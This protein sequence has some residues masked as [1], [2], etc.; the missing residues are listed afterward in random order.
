MH[1]KS[2]ARLSL[3]LAFAVAA[4][5]AMAQQIPVTDFAKYADLDEVALSP[6]GEYIALAVPSVDGK[7]T[8]L[9]IVKLAD[10]S[11]VKTLRFGQE[12]H[13]MG[14]TWTDD[15]QIT[16]A[17][18]KR[19]PGEEF[20]RNTGQLMAT[21]LTGDKQ[22]TLFAYVLDDGT[23]RGR[24]K[25]LGSAY[26]EKVLDKEPGKVLV[27][28]YC[29]E[30]DCGEDGD[31]VVFKVDTRTGT[32]QEVERIK[33]GDVSSSLVFDTDGIARIAYSEESDGTPKLSYRATATSA[34]AP[35]PKSIAGYHL[36]GGV[37]AEDNN[38]LYARVSD[39]GEATQLY[40]IDVA[41]GTRTK[42]VNREGVNVGTIMTATRKE[43]PFGV[44]YTSPS[45]AVQYF[46]NNSEW[47]KLHNALLQRFKGKMVYFLD[48]TRDDSKVLFWTSGD[49]DMGNYY[50]LDRANGNKITQVGARAPWFEGKALAAMKPIEF[51]TRDGVK[52]Y[53]YYTAPV[54]GG[55]GPKPLVV[56]P[57]GGP[58]AVFDA[59][60]FDRDVQF[61]ASRGY[62]VLQVNYRGSGGRGHK[63]IQQAYK[64]WGGMIQNDITDGVKYAIDQKLAD[65]DR[66][67]MYGGSFGGYSALMQPILNPGMYKCA[68]GYVGVYD[69]PLLNS[70]KE[71]EDESV[72][73]FFLRSLGTDAA[74]LGKLS[75]AKR[76]GEVK[77]PVMLVHGKADG[78]VGMNQFRAMDGALK[79][80]GNPAETF[81]GAGEGH[82]FSNPENI[83]ELYRRME[84]FLD[85][86]IGP[87]A[88]VATSP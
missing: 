14:V 41:A 25:D 31:T 83:A 73:R 75:P 62:G 71:S 2:F 13:V 87:N 22:R 15:D 29:W 23:K 74:S 17:R 44:T 84:A 77:V 88:K 49:R 66:I 52:L 39:E 7:E 19:Y 42:M 5:V 64:E 35:L 72:E 6:T 21:N 38:T 1:R 65:P 12:S 18:A 20:L 53:G 86:H 54:G 81:L 63:F 69:L 56:M 40:K 27:N 36:V 43:V 16:V 70:S 28:F 10:G 76:A 78:N 60:G 57:H 34:W 79:D 26:L 59:W 37:F 58:F 33:D 24:N 55:A 47:A 30:M 8:N 51:T 4:P 80:A 67:C 11:T 68:I 9:Q 32:R 3:A 50:V 85:K 61:L 82:G 45:P 46:D 48:F